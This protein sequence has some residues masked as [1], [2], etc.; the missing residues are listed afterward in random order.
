MDAPCRDRAASEQT[1]MAAKRVVRRQQV[2]QQ[3]AERSQSLFLRLRGAVGLVPSMLALLFF[4]T[5]SGIA[6]YGTHTRK[7]AI[8]RK[9]EHPVYAEVGFELV[10]EQQTQRLRQAAREA[11]P[12]YHRINH[13]LIA[14]I[15]TELQNLY[16]AAQA[17]E[18][19]DAFQQREDGT[20]WAVHEAAYERLRS[21]S[22]DVSGSTNPFEQSI[23]RL[24]GRL[25]KENTWNPASASERTP[26]SRADFVLVSAGEIG[27]E[28]N[29]QQFKE[30]RVF[31]LTPISN[32]T[33][34][35]RGADD[36][37]SRSGFAPELR[38]AVA[39]ILVRRM[40]DSPMLQFD[41]SRTNEEMVHS[42]DG[43]EPVMVRYER[44]QPLIP[45]RPDQGLT[46]ADSQLLA[47]HD[48][49]YSAFL[50]SDR[51]GAKALRDRELLRQVGT[52]FLLALTTICLFTYVGMYQPRI[53]QVQT[54]CLA[55]VALLLIALV[56]ARLFEARSPIKELLFAPPLYAAAILT[57]A[58]TRRFAMGIISITAIILCL[59][60]RGDAAMLITLILAAA[61]TVLPLKEIRTRERLIWVGVM[62]A[63]AIF[64][65]STAFE[66]IDGQALDFAAIGGVKAAVGALL[67]AMFVLATLPLIERV[68]GIATS[69]TLLEWRDPTRPLLQRLAQ[70]APG[71][72]T[73]S[74]ALGTLAEAACRTVDA[75]GLL[76]QVGAL[77][78]DVG[79]LHKAEYFAENQE[80]AINRHDNLAPTMS[81]L[82]IIGHVKDGMEMAKEYKLPRVLHQ[83]IQEHHGTTVVRYFHHMA[84]EKQ[85][86]IARGKHDR[87]VPEA[88]FRYPGPK[89]KSKESAVLMLCDGVEGAVRAIGEPTPGRIEHTVHAIVT[90]RL[91]DGQ[92]DDCDITLRELYRVEESLVKSLCSQYHGRMAYPKAREKGARTSER[93]DET[94]RKSI[95]G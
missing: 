65:A 7:Y 71:T 27:G 34:L 87:E 52:V 21:Y 38:E 51:E 18:T 6:L 53:F 29:E 33:S 78:H 48:A 89:P 69:L 73:H 62:S 37:A 55:L 4:L 88:Q 58:Y 86:Q 72:Y 80:A 8:G 24:R 50:A 68:F 95:A 45:P 93:P 17:F 23:R 75:N 16:Q 31:N 5:V 32:L 3:R 46:T 54:R 47:D 20:E 44:G 57:V 28:D 10:D 74:L 39:G 63:C 81:L 25:L 15:G 79:K 13:D 82:I 22:A 36:L 85:P 11:T 83:F 61:A 56:T 41:L 40:S 64:V 59:C 14:H 42:A 19:Y 67:S 2:R 77:Y 91:G 30:V 66:L 84:S 35:T 26:Q 92:F 49:A 1:N 70:E 12:S 94:E 76:A 90:D 43:V 60:L 9:I